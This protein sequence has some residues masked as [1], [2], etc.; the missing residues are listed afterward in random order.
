[1]S[2]EIQQK[3]WKFTHPPQFDRVLLVSR[4]SNKSVRFGRAVEARRNLEYI[5]PTCWKEVC[6]ETAVTSATLGWTSR[7]TNYK[8]IVR[9]RAGRRKT[10][11]VHG[12]TMQFQANEL[13]HNNLSN[14]YPQSEGFH[15]TRRTAHLSRYNHETRVRNGQT[16]LGST[17]PLDPRLNHS[18]QL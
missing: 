12:A 15:A 3:I 2:E 17:N 13:L 14:Q 5:T 10:R 11:K 7:M 1:M 8:A 4:T 9:K 18:W 6:P 16:R